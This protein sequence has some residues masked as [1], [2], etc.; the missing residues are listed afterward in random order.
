MPQGA[1]VP[2]QPPGAGRRDAF[3][4]VGAGV[5]EG[6]VQAADAVV[7]GGDE[8]EI[9]GAPG[10]E[11]A[12]GEHA[13]QSETG[14][15]VDI[16][17]A[18]LLPFTDQQRIDPAVVRTG[19]DRVVIEERHRLVHVMQHLCVPASVGVDDIAGERQRGK[20]G[21]AVV[22]V[23]NVV[24]PVEQARI[25]RVR[26]GAMPVVEIDHAFPSVGFDHRRDQGDHLRANRADVGCFVHGQSIGQFHQRT[27]VSGFGRV[28]RAGDVVDRNRLRDQFLGT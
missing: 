1:G 4:G 5:A 13:R 28:D 23:G 25:L 2:D 24:A 11:L 21:V 8:H 17:P 12:V 9:P 6:F 19:T 18:E 22:V 27:G 20:H 15:G 26:M 14:Q 3:H 7:G 10:I 16:V